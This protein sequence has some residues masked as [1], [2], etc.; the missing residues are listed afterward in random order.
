V[1]QQQQQ[2]QKRQE[3]LRQQQQLLQFNLQEGP[4]RHTLRMQQQVVSTGWQRPAIASNTRRDMRGPC[5]L[6]HPR[7]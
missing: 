4:T 3:L 6:S 2:Q 5:M 1:L 7:T